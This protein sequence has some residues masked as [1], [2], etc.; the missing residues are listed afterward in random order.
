MIAPGFINYLPNYL[1]V[2][3]IITLLMCLF[4]SIKYIFYYF[5]EQKSFLEF[6]KYSSNDLSDQFFEIMMT[7]YVMI[8]G[9]ITFIYIAAA[10]Q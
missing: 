9:L 3:T 1:I 10:I 6:I 8:S 7:V 2:M 4:I 5:S